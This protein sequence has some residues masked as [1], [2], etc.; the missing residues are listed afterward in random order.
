MAQVLLTIAAVDPSLSWLAC[1]LATPV[2]TFPSRGKGDAV[3]VV[4]AVVDTLHPAGQ[5]ARQS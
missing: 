5:R 1:R 2:P 4:M 3:A